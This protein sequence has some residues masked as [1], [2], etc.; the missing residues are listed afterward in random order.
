MC[1]VFEQKESNRSIVDR[2]V[3]IIPIRL[4]HY[5]IQKSINW[6][7]L[8]Q[9]I[10]VAILGILISAKVKNIP[11]YL[12]SS[13]SDLFYLVSFPVGYTYGYSN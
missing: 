12:S 2:E 5:R 3:S 8:F 9:E 11:K 10:F 4:L 13:L 6:K 7:T 1:K